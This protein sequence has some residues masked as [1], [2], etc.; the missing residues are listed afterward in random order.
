VTRTGWLE[1]R[2]LLRPQELSAGIAGLVIGG[3]F[4]SKA[5]DVCEKKW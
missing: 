2:L 1:E 3:K 4:D 5:V